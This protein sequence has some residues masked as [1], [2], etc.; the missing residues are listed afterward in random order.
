M[1]VRQL[2]NRLEQ[3]ATKYGDDH[4][5]HVAVETWH[6]GEYLGTARRLCG[7]LDVIRK[8]WTFDNRRTALRTFSE[9]LVLAGWRDG[10]PTEE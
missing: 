4:P 7:A 1:T 2:I 6:W 8:P 3:A 9:K 5:V 10:G